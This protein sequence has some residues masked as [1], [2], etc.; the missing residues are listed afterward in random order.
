MRK[1]IAG[2]ILHIFHPE[3]QV[4][5]ADVTKS[6]ESARSEVYVYQRVSEI[7]SRELNNIRLLAQKLQ[8]TEVARPEG[9]GDSH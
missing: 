5:L 8:L 3:A 4:T 2:E 1:D 9:L 6:Q 7:R